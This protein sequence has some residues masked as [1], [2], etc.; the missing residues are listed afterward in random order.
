MA[1]E[2]PLLQNIRFQA[3]PREIGRYGK[4]G[5][6]AGNYDHKTNNKFSEIL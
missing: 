6:G 5:D 4:K 2:W 3:T 1:T